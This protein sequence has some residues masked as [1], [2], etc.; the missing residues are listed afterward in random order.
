M[1]YPTVGVLKMFLSDLRRI[2]ELFDLRETACWTCP[3]EDW[4][5]TCSACGGSMRVWVGRAWMLSDEQ[6]A[7][8]SRERPSE[9]NAS[10]GRNADSNQP[11]G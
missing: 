1:G 10:A 2:A 9:S 5:P 6:L 11:E 7:Q 4:A 3:A 8:L